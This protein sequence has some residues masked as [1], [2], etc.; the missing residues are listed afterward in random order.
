MEYLAGGSCLDLVSW[1]GGNDARS[2][3]NV[4]VEARCLR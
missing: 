4:P 3:A 2:E 1:V